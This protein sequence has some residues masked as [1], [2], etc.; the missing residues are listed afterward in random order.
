[1]H[2]T[3][4]RLSTT[5][6]LAAARALIAQLPQADFGRFTVQS[7]H[8]YESVPGGGGSKYSKLEEFPLL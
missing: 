3:L 6:G 8:L 4:A 7:F 5:D 2:L 1:M